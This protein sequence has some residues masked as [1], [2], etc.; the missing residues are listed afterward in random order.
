MSRSGAAD[1][2]PTNPGTMDWAT[3]DRGMADRVR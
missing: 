2:G 1:R 3:M